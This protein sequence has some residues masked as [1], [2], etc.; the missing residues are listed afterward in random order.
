MSSKI[1]LRIAAAV[2]LLHSVGHTFGVMTWQDPNGEIPTEVVQKMQD[3]QFSFMGKDGSTMAEFYSGFGYC[4]TILT[5][6]IAALLWIFS[7]WKDKSVTKTLWVTGL[8]TVMLAVVEMIYFFPMAVALCL[9]TAILIF[10]SIF[11]IKKS[12]R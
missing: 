3:V 7:G 8:A 11:L 12:S 10:I 4:G 9:L 1:L 6:F 5:V 2:M